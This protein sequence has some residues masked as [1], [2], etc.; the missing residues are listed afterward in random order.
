VP[1]GAG[2]VPSIGL[3]LLMEFRCFPDSGA[4]GLNSF[5]ISL[6]NLNSAQPNFRAF[7]TGGIGPGNTLVPKDPDLQ[8]SATGGFNPGSNPPGQTTLGADNS[9]YIGEA[10]LVTRISRAHSIWFDTGS[11]SLPQYSTPVLEPRAEDQ[12]LGTQ[13]VLAFRGSN[14]VTATAAQT[15]NIL[16]DS[17]GLDPYGDVRPPIPTATPPFPGSG[18]VVFPSGDFTWKPSLGQISGLRFFQVRVTFVSNAQTN[19][20]PTLSALGFAY[21]L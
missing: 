16:N 17:D 21:R 15:T 10:E 6:A 13:I 18:T 9:F 5:D 12:P 4:L 3:P 19:L 2:S 20:S 14:S 1:Y 8:T 11:G 7:S